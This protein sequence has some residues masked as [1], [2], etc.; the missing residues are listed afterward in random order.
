MDAS[1]AGVRTALREFDASGAFSESAFS[2]LRLLLAGTAP[3]ELV[4]GLLGLFFERHILHDARRRELLA[5]D[6]AALLRALR[7][8]FRQVVADGQEGHAAAHALGPHVREGLARMSHAAPVVPAPWPVLLTEGERF[9]RERVE[10]ALRA[11]AA[12]LG[13]WPTSAEAVRELLRRYAQVESEDRH[14]DTGRF[15]PPEAL[16]RRMDARRLAGQLLEVL[17]PQERELLRHLLVDEGNVEDWAREQ[18]I[19]RA[20]AYRVLARLKTVCRA[21]L[22]GRSNS[23]QLK[24]LEELFGGRSR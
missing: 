9:S 5:M 18:G 13:R 23:T 3:G 6:D 21:E 24:A 20:T 14:E 15:D 17:K 2:A 19:A 8:R 10:E 11:Q 1:L 7:H 12:E 4:D 22:E 16:R